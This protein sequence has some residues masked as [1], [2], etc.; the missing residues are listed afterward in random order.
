MKTTPNSNRLHIGIFGKTNSGKSSLMNA[1][2]DQNTSI[3]SNVEGT[4]TDSV[5]KAMEFLPFGPVLL[6]D[7]PGLEDS[8]V[9]SELREKKALGELKRTDFAILVVDSTK[10]DSYFYKKMVSQFKKYNIPFLFVQNK[11]DLLSED[12]KVKLQDEFKDSILVSTLE[13]E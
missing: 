1:I 8:T 13:R 6:I 2:T 7:T 10:Q 11:I 4:T 3:V 12:E 5:T 9:L